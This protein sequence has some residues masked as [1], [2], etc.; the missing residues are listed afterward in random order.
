[1]NGSVLASNKPSTE[2]MMIHFTDEWLITSRKW[3]KKEFK[4]FI[5]M[6]KYARTGPKCARCW[7]H[8]ANSGPALACYGRSMEHSQLQKSPY[9]MDDIRVTWHEHH[10]TKSQAPWLF[11]QQL[12]P[13]NIKENIKATLC[14]VNPLVTGGFPH[15]GPVMCKTFLMSWHHHDRLPFAITQM[16]TDFG[17][18]WHS[19]SPA[20]GRLVVLS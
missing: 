15:K 17:G 19:L 8:S 3:L 9:P 13:A 12:V 16:E 5:N 2:P 11:I 4:N 18:A 20:F 10:G 1:M 14:V 6:A 7:Q